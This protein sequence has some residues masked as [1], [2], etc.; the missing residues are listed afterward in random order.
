MR[1][2]RLSAA[3]RIALWG[4]LPYAAATLLLGVGVYVATHLAF[5]RQIDARI[6]Q[7]TTALL[8]I[9]FPKRIPA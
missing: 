3:N 6:E 9:R 1:V 4:W 8:K 5:S 7:A 2:G